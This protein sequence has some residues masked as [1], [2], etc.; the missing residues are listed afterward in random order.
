MGSSFATDRRY[1]GTGAGAGA[2]AGACSAQHK[3]QPPSRRE[4]SSGTSKT[5]NSM[6]SGSARS[7]YHSTETTSASDI[8]TATAGSTASLN[9]GEGGDGR[10]VTDSMSMRSFVT[11]EEM[12]EVNEGEEEKAAEHR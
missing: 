3:R 6:V 7:A 1:A 5:D 2:G 9:G 12:D 11:A 8:R 4:F 10:S